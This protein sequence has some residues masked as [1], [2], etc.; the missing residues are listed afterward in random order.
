[1]TD[2]GEVSTVHMTDPS[3]CSAKTLAWDPDVGKA[4]EVHAVGDCRAGKPKEVAEKKC[5]KT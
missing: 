2:L 1:M 5:H 4:T 3:A